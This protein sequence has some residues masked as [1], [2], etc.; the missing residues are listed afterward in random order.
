[1]GPLRN[2]QCPLVHVGTLDRL[3]VFDVTDCKRQAIIAGL[4]TQLGSRYNVAHGHNSRS[5]RLL[6]CPWHRIGCAA[7]TN[8]LRA[9]EAVK[10]V[11]K[12][13]CIKL[14]IFMEGVHLDARRI[15]DLIEP[16]RRRLS[17]ARRSQGRTSLAQE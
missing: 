16:R 5:A 9:L 7:G 6:L 8:H 14:G 4:A 13:P 11:S 2:I 3:S 15:V 10:E 1:M 17:R 12:R